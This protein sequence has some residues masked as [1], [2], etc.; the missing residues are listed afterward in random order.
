MTVTNKSALNPLGIEPAQARAYLVRIQEQLRSYMANNGFSKVVVGCSG[1]IDSAIT[2]ALAAGAIGPENVVGITMPSAY[3][4]AG[5]V[6]DSEKLCENLGVTLLNCSIR[7]IVE[8]T[9]DSMQES[10]GQK[11]VGLA[12]ENLQA[13]ARGV[14]LM[15]YSNLNGHLVLATGNKS[16]AS[17]GYCTLYGDTCGG[18]NL[19]GDLYKTEVYA[20]AREFNNT[21]TAGQIPT[22]ILEKAPSAELA[23]GQK[24]S[25]SLPEYDQ[26]DNALLALQGKATA[27]AKAK[28]YL[29]ESLSISEIELLLAR[30]QK[31]M[32]SS[33][34][35]RLQLPPV[36][37]LQ[38]VRDEWS[39]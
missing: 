1:G 19:I 16:E 6:T 13:R 23:P 30:V 34:F 39:N 27:A 20:V 11:P 5:S 2:I 35:K 33:Q 22:E 29:G 9:S 14:I 25:D 37:N 31:L 32:A 38:P 17:V 4:S 7:D 18:L 21:S 15:T 12:L 36:V 3:S 28:S 10:V 8:Q 24:D 26:L